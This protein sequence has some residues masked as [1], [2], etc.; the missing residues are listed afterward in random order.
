MYVETEGILA[1]MEN[2]TTKD[3]YI[4]SYLLATHAVQF[5]GVEGEQGQKYFVFSPQ[6]KAQELA[7]AYWNFKAENIQPK[8]LFS[9]FRDIKDALFAS[10]PKGGEKYGRR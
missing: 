3:L 7:D 10:Q 9:A 1:N 6:Q 2:Y 4:A 5:V 8:Q